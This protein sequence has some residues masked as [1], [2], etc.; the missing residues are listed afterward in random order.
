MLGMSLS[1]LL[2]I[3]AAHD[4]LRGLLSL[5]QEFESVPDDKFDRKNVSSVR[6]SLKELQLIRVLLQQR[7]LFR[8]ASRA[9]KSN[10]GGVDF[11][12]GL[13]ES[14]DA[15]Y[16]ITPNIVRLTTLTSQST[17]AD[18]LHL[19]PFELD[20]NQVFLTTCD[21]LIETYRKILTHLGSASSPSSF[22]QP[23]SSSSATTFSRI[24]SSGERTGAA[25][26]SPAL[27]DVVVKI[28]ARLKVRR[29]P[30]ASRVAQI[31]G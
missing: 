15:S 9:R 25:G 22:P 16:L 23:P 11:T 21:M 8:V 7:G 28:D 20:Y 3:P 2:D 10:T 4:F 5:V 31:A 12:M 14:G 27:T 1:A 26:L 6:R 30:S 17:L 13:P 29:R 19:Q 24:V 18:A